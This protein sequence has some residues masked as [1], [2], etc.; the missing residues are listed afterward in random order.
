MANERKPQ[1]GQD[2]AHPAPGRIDLNHASKEDLMEIPGIDPETATSLLRFRDRHGGIRSWKDF[3][4]SNL[5]GEDLD[6]LRPYV[7]F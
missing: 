3:D 2:Q 4:E 7:R 5:P 6:K 1:D